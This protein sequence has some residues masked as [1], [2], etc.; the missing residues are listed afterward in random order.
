MLLVKMHSGALKFE[1]AF[2]QKHLAQKHIYRLLCEAIEFF[3]Y[4]NQPILVEENC[5]FGHL[6]AL[7]AAHK[8][9]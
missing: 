1:S 9:S 5:N 6:E 4:F 2:D 8:V 3:I 7:L